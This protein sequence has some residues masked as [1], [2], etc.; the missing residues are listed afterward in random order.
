MKHLD[1]CL[2]SLTQVSTLVRQS[3]TY[4]TRNAWNQ[5][6]GIHLVQVGMM[7]VI[8]SQPSSLTSSDLS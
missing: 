2:P 4:S 5:A 8:E 6:R 1:I 3:R 7:Y